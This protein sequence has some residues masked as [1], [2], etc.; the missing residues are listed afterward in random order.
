MLNGAASQSTAIAPEQIL[1]DQA[2]A[3]Y[4]Q[5]DQTCMAQLSAPDSF[6]GMPPS[7]LLEPGADLNPLYE[8]L[9]GEHPAAVTNKPILVLQGLADTTVFPFFTDQLT[10]ELTALGDEVTYTTYPG[11]D[12]G[13]IPA[14]SATQALAFMEQ[15][16]PRADGA[17]QVRGLPDGISS[18]TRVP[19]TRG[20]G[21]GAVVARKRS[22]WPGP[23]ASKAASTAV[24]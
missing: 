1:T 11:V 21:G 16:L 13:S 4:P 8:V 17:H 6:G 12:H 14:A 5:T 7:D 9:E 3:L 2:L 19:S 24:G 18:R 22:S 10:A 15:R 20:A 23:R